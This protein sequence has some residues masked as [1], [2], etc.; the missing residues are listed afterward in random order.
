MHISIEE[1]KESKFFLNTV[2]DTINSAVFIIDSKLKIVDINNCSKI[3]FKTDNKEL[4]GKLLG[5]AIN[6]IHAIS[7]DIDCG[8]APDCAEC[9]LRS[10]ILET[11]KTKSQSPKLI[12]DRE[13]ILSRRKVHKIFQYSTKFFNFNN[14]EMVIVIIDDITKFELQKKKLKTLNEEK[15]KFISYAVHDLRS[16][17][18]VIL[19]YLEYFS[20]FLDENLTDKQKEVLKKLEDTTHSMLEL[21]NDILS[22]T[23]I[24]AGKLEIKKQKTDYI[25]LLLENIEINKMLAKKKKI[26][27]KFENSLKKIDLHIDKKKI[28]EVFNNLVNNAI[29]YSNPETQIRI[30]VTKKKDKITTEVID[31]GPGIKEEEITKLFKPFQRASVQTTAGETSNGLGLAISKKIVKAHN[32]EIGVTSK[33]GFGSNFFYTLPLENKD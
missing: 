28:A 11:F 22:I 13:L 30:V 12:L 23:K 17:I 26:D 27:I 32:G 9:K 21:T 29:K 4:K 18:S 16:P 1:L 3:L 8:K 14:I 2:L 20:E 5:N 25:E 33:V 15:N 19:M 10:T 24:D 6:C 31:Q 7:N